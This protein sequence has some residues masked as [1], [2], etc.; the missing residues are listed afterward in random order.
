MKKLHL[1][2]LVSSLSIGGAEQ[3]LLDLLRN[4]DRERFEILI[5]MLREPGMVGQEVL[6]LGYRSRFNILHRRVDL[7][8]IPR[9]ARLL[10]SEQTDLLFLIN[11]RNT[12]FYGVPAAKLAGVTAIVNWENETFKK[13]SFN[14]LTV[15]N[16]RLFHLGVD[17]VVAA[18]LGHRD[19]IISVERVPARKVK[20]IYNGVDPARFR[21]KLSPTEARGRLGIPEQSPVVSIIGVLRPDKAH[22]VFLEAAQAV[23]RAVPD[24]HFLIVGD[25]PEREALTEQVQKMGIGDRVHFLGFRRDLADV[26]AAVDVNALSS[27]PRQETLSVA[28]IEA[29]SAGIPTVST[30]VG[31]MGEVVIP[32]RTGYLVPVG[33]ASALAERLVLLLQGEELR[34]A[35]SR[36]TVKLVEE[37]LSVKQMCAEFEEFLEETYLLKQRSR[38]IRAE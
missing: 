16:H 32:N 13:Y 4:I 26:L 19:Y 14:A 23:L 20:V 1:T 8:G 21:S 11:H 10:K 3:L 9:L 18:A 34:R 27:W 6:R 33:D 29:M 31:F 22:G 12:L 36:H 35:M 5:C 17:G 38:G 30:D 25:G 28:V 37:Q 15:L 7:P 24:T 2:F